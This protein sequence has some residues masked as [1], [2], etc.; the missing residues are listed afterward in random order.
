MVINR[1]HVLQASLGSG[2]WYEEEQDSDLEHSIL[3]SL[4][5]Q[6][7]KKTKLENIGFIS[8][9][10]AYSVDDA[11]LWKDKHANL[12]EQ[13]KHFKETMSTMARAEDFALEHTIQPQGIEV[14]E[15]RV[16]WSSVPQRRSRAT[17]LG[18][19]QEI[20]SAV[21][22]L[23]VKEEAEKPVMGA[24]PMQSVREQALKS[25]H[26]LLSIKDGRHKVHITYRHIRMP[27]P[28]EDR[29]CLYV[30]AYVLFDDAVLVYGH[31]LD[32]PR[33]DSF[34]RAKMQYQGLVALPTSKEA[35]RKN[36]IVS[37][38]GASRLVHDNTAI[39]EIEIFYLLNC[40]LGGFIPTS[41]N[42]EATSFF[43]R[44]PLTVKKRAIA[45]GGSDGNEEIEKIDEYLVP[46][47]PLNES[48]LIC[49]KTK[50]K[51]LD[52]Q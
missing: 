48:D 18:S 21:Y 6:D 4:K 33:R 3:S 42:M 26:E 44:L 25:D 39:S 31:N 14:W 50:H 32:G 36:R 5:R 45:A 46:V 35:L 47:F 22:D 43:L 15:R 9:L 40:D 12:D 30:I 10:P 2:L 19:L 20:F 49:D 7:S 34:V 41:L 11:I 38:S 52:E 28:L 29:D 1:I 13:H 51:T 27:W 24:I 17:F 8:E 16:D 23:K 37:T